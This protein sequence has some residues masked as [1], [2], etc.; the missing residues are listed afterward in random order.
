MIPT[1]TD[2]VIVWRASKVAM[3]YLSSC[4]S[5]P[6]EFMAYRRTTSS[7]VSHVADRFRFVSSSN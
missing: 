6:S 5:A 1:G 7:R 3:H 2:V 4:G